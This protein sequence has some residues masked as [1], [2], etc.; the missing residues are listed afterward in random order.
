MIINYLNG[1]TISEALTSEIVHNYTEYINEHK[2]N[3]LAAFEYIKATCPDILSGIDISELE[4]NVI[5]HDDSKFSD[6]EFEPY[7]NRWFGDKLKTPEYEKAWEH[8]W[9]SN[10]HHP[11]YWQGN[12]MP[13]IYIIE[14]ICDWLS[15]SIKKG[16]ITELFDFYDNKAKDDPEKMLSNKTKQSIEK[17]ISSIKEVIKV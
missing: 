14:M 16:D 2:K 11:E 10:P 13:D 6:E 12:D 17:Y 9:Q 5:K 4:I 15:F 8:H 1:S 7:A 3:V